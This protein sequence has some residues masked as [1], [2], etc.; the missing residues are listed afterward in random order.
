MLR[1]YLSNYCLKQPGTR[2]RKLLFA[3]ITPTTA[4][5]NI[6]YQ[7]DE[8]TKNFVVQSIGPACTALAAEH[9][10]SHEDLTALQVYGEPNGHRI[11]LHL[12]GSIANA[13]FLDEKNEPAAPASLVAALAE[14]QAHIEAQ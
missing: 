14:I 11:E 12:G 7:A 2:M 1:T 4:T 9:K 13:A 8:D 6:T 5:V 3:L 10:A